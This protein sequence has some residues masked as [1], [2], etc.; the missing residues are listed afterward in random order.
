LANARSNSRPMFWRIVRRLIAANRGRLVVILLALG[1]GAAVTAALL[2][3]QIDAKKRLTSEFRAFGANVVVAPKSGDSSP[4]PTI[5]QILDERIPLTNDGNVVTRID[6]LYLLVQANRTSPPPQ[7]AKSDRVHP[8]TNTILS[9]SKKDA[10]VDATESASPSISVV[11]VGYEGRNPQHIWP[12]Q[13][14]EGAE[15]GEDC[16]VGKNAAKALQVRAGDYLR[17]RNRTN[18]RVCLVS[19]VEDFGG[20]E[21]NQILTSSLFSVQQLNFV[22]QGV[23]VSGGPQISII[24]LSVPGPP[25]SISNYISNL[26]QQIPE[27][28]VHGIRQFTE[29]EG[30]IYERISGLLTATVAVVLILTTL[31]VMAAMTNVAMER[32]NDVGLMKAIGGATRRVLR[33]FLAEAAT[34]G[35]IAGII[36]AA[37][38]LALSVVLG[39]AVFGVPAQPRLIVY[40]VVVA[41][42]ILVAVAGAYP[43]RRLAGIR[44]ASVFRGEA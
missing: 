43:L 10:A 42:T 33:L 9:P 27:A 39:K 15:R 20:A 7:I 8:P 21:D 22:G 14:L 1:A 24:Q 19:T 44:P 23:L 2:N 37:A 41:L 38:G 30:K 13:I 26:Q 4:N 16:R 17:L 3:L 12:T 6:L 25:Q 18:K 35:L 5:P 31:C 28:D 29:G 34:L 32:K 36:G 11:L 40:P